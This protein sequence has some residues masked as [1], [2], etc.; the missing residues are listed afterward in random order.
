MRKFQLLLLILFCA[1]LWPV[2][3]QAQVLFEHREQ[4]QLSRDVTF[5]RIR[6]VTSAGFMDIYVMTVPLNDP[7]ISLAPVESGYQLGQRE[8][9]LNLLNEAGAI[10]GVNADF[11][12]LR[13]THSL[14]FG[15]V[16]DNGQLMSITEE[17]NHGINEFATFFLDESNIPLIRYITPRIWFTVNGI[18]MINVASIN[19]VATFDRPIIIT[20]EGMLDTRQLIEREPDLFKVVVDNGIITR[21]VSEPVVV[22]ENGFVIVMNGEEFIRNNPSFLIGM[23]AQ[24]SVFTNFERD[25]SQIQTAIGG[26]NMILRNGHAVPGVGAATRGRAPRTALGVTIDMQRLILMVVDGRGHSIGATHEDMA[27]F[28]LRFGAF[29]AMHFDGG[30]STTMVAQTGG[31]GSPLQVVNRVS[32]GS[33]RRIINALGV[34]DHSTPGEAAQLVLMPYDRNILLGHP[35]HLHA[36]GLDLYRH[37]IGLNPEALT[38]SAYI[39]DANGQQ[40]PAAGIWSGNIFTPNQTGPLYVHVQYGEL[41]VSKTYFVQEAAITAF[42]NDPLRSTI[43]AANSA[44]ALA[45]GLSL[46]GD[47]ALAYAT[48]QEG[49]VAILQMT[50]A[51]GGIFATDR[52][53]WGRF[54][55]D[56]NGMAPD[57]VI[58]RMDANPL[59]TLSR[60]EFDVFHQALRTQQAMGRTVFVVSNRGEAAAFSLRDGIRYIDLGNAGS[61][62]QIRFRIDGQQI[63]YDF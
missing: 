61:S 38:F 28:M 41:A 1:A 46:P 47:G 12:G 57:H 58:I 40:Q 36:Y 30:G 4:T 43:T 62:H 55:N 53:Q 9:A 5:E 39:M 63:R 32:E 60:D 45:F 50:A 2:Q 59:L 15:P 31:H 14:A 25:I 13:G 23:P 17:L 29:D 33:Q 18:E 20:R 52:S 51:S 8:T 16:I 42:D 6:Q 54:L 35:L 22:P 19:K 27:A 34:F 7:Y 26:G 10:G 56:I 49:N 44:G 3:A 37:R 24:Y 21:V 48:R 11:F